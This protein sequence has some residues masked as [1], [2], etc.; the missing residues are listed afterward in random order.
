MAT[1]GMLLLLIEGVEGESV[2]IEHHAR[3]C[4]FDGYFS[5]GLSVC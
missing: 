4:K 3:A 1:K 5:L 2:E